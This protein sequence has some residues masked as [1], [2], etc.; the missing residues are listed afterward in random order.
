M[1]CVETVIEFQIKVCHNWHSREIIFVSSC[2]IKRMHI[3]LVLVWIIG[4]V[5]IKMYVRTVRYDKIELRL[6]ICL[7]QTQSVASDQQI[8]KKGRKFSGIL[9]GRIAFIC[10]WLTIWW[11]RCNRRRFSAPIRYRPWAHPPSYTM[12][13]GYFQGVK[14]AGVWHWPP[15]PSRVEVKER[16]ELYLYSKSGP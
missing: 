16:V 8:L 4:Q 14:R 2:N 11:H 15:T 1:C 13:T 9:G 6:C 5:V 3:A 7:R 12:G 10:P